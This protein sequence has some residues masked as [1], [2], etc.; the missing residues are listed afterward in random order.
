[1]AFDA[2]STSTTAN[3]YCTVEEADSYFTYRFDS[4]L[5]PT[6]TL[7][8]QKILVTA[9]RRID[10]EY[11]NGYKSNSARTLQFPRTGLVDRDGYQ[12]GSLTIPQNL[13][14]AVC[15]L[16]YSYLVTRTFSDAEM[17]DMENLDSFS[18]SVDGISVSY[19]FKSNAVGNKLPANVEAE[20]KAIGPNVWKKHNNATYILR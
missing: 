10:Q 6:S 11:F 19:S 18:T 1:M 9:S 16:A 13:I 17:M 3:S 2:S 20:L 7:M 14:N 12:I 4:C 8:K 15:E 5:Y